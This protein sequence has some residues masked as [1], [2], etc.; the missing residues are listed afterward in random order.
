M[1]TIGGRRGGGGEGDAEEGLVDYITSSA[2]HVGSM[3]EQYTAYMGQICS[4][5]MARS[6]HTPVVDKS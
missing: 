3:W 2:T 5:L 1:G 4:T 6:L